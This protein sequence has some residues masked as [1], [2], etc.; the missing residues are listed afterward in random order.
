VT[1][2]FTVL[3]VCTANQCRSA[4]AEALAADELTGFPGAPLRF[5][6]AGT[7]ALAGSPATEGTVL[8]M[9][10]RG[11]DL[12]SHH[13]RELSRGVLAEAD[14][15]LVM[16][17]EHRRVVQ[18]W[19]R[20]AGRRTFT[21]MSFSRAIAGRGAESPEVLVDLANEYGTTEPDDDV[22]D[23]V[24]RGKAAHE[25]CADQL[26]A[27]IRPLVRVLAASAGHDA[28]AR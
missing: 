12:L 17:E 18:A 24:G 13:A 19:E 14:L 15:V 8:T 25:R 22:I 27:L 10:E 5:R 3:F 26:E 23:P 16:A 2:P 28:S 6:S 21:L 11:V 9:E 7:N 4:M 20:S 1:E